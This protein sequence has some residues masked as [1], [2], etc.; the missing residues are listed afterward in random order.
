MW[1]TILFKYVLPI[2]FILGLLAQ[3][4]SH[5][6]NAGAAS[7][8]AE[9]LEAEADQEVKR[10]EAIKH[11]AEQVHIKEENNRQLI[12]EI[13]NERTEKIKAER[14]AADRLRAG[15]LW[16]S[17]KACPGNSV[18]SVRREAIDIGGSDSGTDRVRLSEQDENALIEYA[19]DAQG[20][21]RQYQACRKV[22]ARLTRQ[23]DQSA[24]E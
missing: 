20:V 16:V 24:K 1:A 7:K 18:S 13:I 5:V 6:Y 10:Q 17:T 9:W 21:V 3:G 11:V 8:N 15:G 12:V 23:I 2:A 19:E 4:V 14:I 22:L